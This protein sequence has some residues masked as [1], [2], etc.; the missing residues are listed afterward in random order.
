[1]VH[2]RAAV[3]LEHTSAYAYVLGLS[4][5]C[6]SEHR[7][8]DWLNKDD[9]S[10]LTRELRN[11]AHVPDGGARDLLHRGP[12]YPGQSAGVRT[13]KK[14]NRCALIKSRSTCEV[15]RVRSCYTC[16][17]ICALQT[18]VHANATVTHEN[19][20]VKPTNVFMRRAIAL[21]EFSRV[22]TR[23]FLATP[24]PEPG[25]AYWT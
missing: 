9:K 14:Y 15:S 21:S 11:G 25:T 12:R 10:A 24:S 6:R 4:Q 16:T 7:P 23:A 8:V 18:R 5:R 2:V 17:H 19:P 3:V 22:D 13:G 20:A 1:M